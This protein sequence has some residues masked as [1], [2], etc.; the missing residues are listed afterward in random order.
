MTTLEE[1]FIKVANTTHTQAE[2]LAGKE[3]GLETI[4]LH[5]VQ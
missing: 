2:A 3:K 1:V 4:I 5:S